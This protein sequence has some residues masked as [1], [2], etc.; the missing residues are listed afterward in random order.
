MSIPKEPR[1]LMINLMYLVLTAMLAINVSSEIL[2]AFSIINKSINT[3][4]NSIDQ[5]NG[6]TIQNFEEALKEKKVL[7]DP[8]K[9]ARIEAALVRAKQVREETTTMVNQILGYKQEIIKQSGGKIIDS[10]TSDSVLK[11]ES[12]LDAA[13]VVMIEKLKRG[14]QMK[15]QLESYKKK[16]IEL[17][18]KPS[19]TAAVLYSAGLDSILPITFDYGTKNGIGTDEQWAFNNFHMV[20]TI[21][22][23]TILDKYVNDVRNSENIVLDQIWAEAF[24]EKV[25]NKKV[26]PVIQISNRFALIGGAENSYLLPGQK[27]TSK[28][29]IG[30]YNSSNTQA[31]YI[32]VNG[33]PIKVVDGVGSFETTAGEPGEKTLKITGTIYDPNIKRSVA[34]TPIDVKYFVGTPAASI[35]LDKMN[36]FYLG[37]DNPITIS[38]SGILM[39]DLIPSSSSN[40]SIT[41][42]SGVG[43]YV[44]RPSGASGTKG[45]ITLSGKR[46][47]GVVQNFGTREYRIKKIPDPIMKYMGSTGGRM[48]SAKAKIGLGPEAILENFDF[49][50]KYAIISYTLTLIIKGEEQNYDIQGPYINSNPN[51]VRAMKM[52]KPKDVM[53]FEKIVV[54]GPDNV[55]RNIPS[56]SFILTN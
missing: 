34:V 9:K 43:S 50:A 17:S 13:T 38:A 21:G 27:Y 30:S 11:A 44:V 19:D 32:A 52:L 33:S 25:L 49:D 46:S 10:K 12:D 3:S 24:G 14:P 26:P 54:M 8:A 6:G 36:V 22:A 47:D 1:Q 2:R 41:S 56:F 39:R 5:K 15:Q 42:G 55:R 53:Y 28:F 16:I 7:E 31:V 48:P 40:I 37:V 45:T 4:N 23:V 29:M 18:A 20:P 51:A 35:S